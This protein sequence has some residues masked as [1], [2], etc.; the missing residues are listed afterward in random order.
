MNNISQITIVKPEWGII[1]LY[2]V[3]YLTAAGTLHK[4]DEFFIIFNF[5]S[6]VSK[7]DF[8]W[9]KKNMF[10]HI[11]MTKHLLLKN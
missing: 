2:F 6:A 1:E 8:F 4:L 5:T 7:K 11:G 10:G 3:L 9:L